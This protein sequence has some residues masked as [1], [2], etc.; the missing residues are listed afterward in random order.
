MSNNLQVY[1]AK[2]N[3]QQAL[4]RIKNSQEFNAVLDAVYD[5]VRNQSNQG[6]LG[7]ELRLDNLLYITFGS[8]VSP[9]IHNVPMEQLAIILGAE[10]SSQGYQIS[11]GQTGLRNR[12][13][14]IR[15]FWGL[16]ED[17]EEED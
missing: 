3:T 2:S 11:Y 17:P 15:V 8:Y 1:F 14:T 5:I 13:R 6:K 12:K 16:P 7:M 9:E 4:D 10:L